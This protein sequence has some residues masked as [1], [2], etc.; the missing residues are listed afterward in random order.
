MAKLKL[1]L[2]SFNARGSIA[3]AISFVKRH[4]QNIVEKKPQVP[5]AKTPAQLSWRHMYQKCAALWH[6]LSDAEQ[7]EWNALASTRHMTG[8]A[9]WQ[10]QCLRPNPGIY[11]PLQGGTMTGAIQMN[12]QHIHGLPLPVHVQDVWRRQDFQDFCLPFHL[13]EGARVYH[14]IGQGIPNDTPT[15][16]VFNSEL[17]DTDGIH[18]NVTNNSRLTCKTAGKYVIT[19]TLSWSTSPFGYRAISVFLNGV[20]ALAYHSTPVNPGVFRQSIATIYDL[21][22][23]DYVEASGFHTMGGVLT[24][25][26]SANFSPHFAMQRIGA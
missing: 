23:G 25:S 12:G 5:D 15:F 10:S 7:A 9:Y 11:L 8:F 18:D 22:V 14:N 1:P 13:T 21:A 19:L 24:V 2:L 26:S 20:L 16:L 6:T 3:K 17:Y 4:G